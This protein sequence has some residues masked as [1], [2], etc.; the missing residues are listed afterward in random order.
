MAFA[1]AGPIKW[2]DLNCAYGF[3]SNA[4]FSYSNV[5]ASTT[6]ASFS[7]ISLSNIQNQAIPYAGYLA[8][9]KFFE[10]AT[11][12]FNNSTEAATRFNNT[13]GVI[14]YVNNLS[15]VTED[16]VCYE[17]SGHI[18]LVENGTHSFNVNT[19][20]GGQLEVNGSIVATYYGS[21]GM[22]GGGTSGTISL[23]AGVYPIK[24]LLQQ[25]GGGIGAE[26]L[27][28]AP[29]AGAFTTINTFGAS[30]FTYA[31]KPYVKLDANHLAFRQGVS[32]NSAIGTWSNMGTDGTAVHATGASGNAS[33]NPTLT[34]NTD[35]YMVTFDRTK[36]QHFTLGTL[37][38]DK[39]R[40]SD[41]L[42]TNGLTIFCVVRFQPGN[43]G[44]WE[45]LID[46]GSGA[47]NDNIIL[48]RIEGQHKLCPTFLNGTG[49]TNGIGKIIDYS[50]MD[51]AF[52][53]YALAITNAS[54]P[55]LTF[56]TDG[57][58]VSSGINDRPGWTP[59]NILNRTITT[60]YIGRSA[61][62]GDAYFGGDIRELQ[63]YREVIPTSL[64]IQMSKYLMLK[65]GVRSDVEFITNGL[66]GY[67]TGESW[68]GTQWNDIS[69][70]ANNATTIRGTPVN[71][72]VTLNG[73]RCLS[74]ATTAG[75]RFPSGLLPT[76]YT[77][78]HVARYNGTRQR[79]FDAYSGNFLSGFHA[80]KA[81]VAYH[82]AWLTPQSDIH[83][84]NWVLSVDQKDLYKSNGTQRS[85]TNGIMT[86]V[87]LSINHGSFVSTESS[88]FAVACVIAYNRTLNSSEIQQ[89][90]LYLN[91]KYRIY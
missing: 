62:G 66:I 33:G 76:G 27:Y 50:Q 42:D 23:N 85:T 86:A 51:G 12:T 67:F 30:N 81:G 82:E 71:N 38:F 29:S 58:Q 7:N 57:Y 69:P 18:K 40:S 22:N 37:T 21:H 79:I 28:R 87:S 24:L 72:S 60:N 25:G 1:S 20:D 34:Q 36:Q 90:E 45:R 3:G 80:N 15:V 77:L 46:F 59:T 75:L 73:F 47:P 65:W 43:I 68:T 16:Y 35:G 17:W 84:N 13:K 78:F 61:W 9:R 63:I 74:G 91:R 53:V 88:D 6:G 41:N 83:G 31:F 5:R 56:I 70:S 19:D 89:M 54:T 14:A 48:S 4:V 11:I 32:V 8:R 39:F 26:I 10:S 52:H 49:Q 2:S 55:T 44:Y 64:M